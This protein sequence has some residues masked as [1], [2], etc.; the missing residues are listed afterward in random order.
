[1]RRG[2]GF[3]GLTDQFVQEIWRERTALMQPPASGG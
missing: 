3:Y 1:M 2:H